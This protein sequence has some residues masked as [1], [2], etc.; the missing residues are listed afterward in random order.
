[1]KDEECVDLKK[2]GVWDA[3]FS[4][5]FLEAISFV[6]ASAC[7]PL[8]VAPSNGLKVAIRGEKAWH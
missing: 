5:S 3:V 4:E 2:Y 8:L 1:M 6:D 7:C